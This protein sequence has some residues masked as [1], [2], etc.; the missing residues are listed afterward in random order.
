MIRKYSFEEKLRVHVEYI[1]FIKQIY[2]NHKTLQKH[3]HAYV[4]VT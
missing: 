4:Y 2:Y 1:S 3:I